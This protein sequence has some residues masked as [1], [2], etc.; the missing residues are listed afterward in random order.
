MNNVSGKERKKEEEEEE[1]EMWDVLRP[2]Y[3]RKASVAGAT[4]HPCFLSSNNDSA[5]E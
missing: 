2:I 5:N 4:I 3:P 1:K